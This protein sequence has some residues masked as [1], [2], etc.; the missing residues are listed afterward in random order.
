MFSFYIP[1][2]YIHGSSR[3][4]E[5]IEPFLPNYTME[6]Y[7]FYVSYNQTTHAFELLSFHIPTKTIEFIDDQFL[8]KNGENNYQLF[9]PYILNSKIYCGIII[10]N[11]LPNDFLVNDIPKKMISFDTKI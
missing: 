4:Y 7:I 6:N 1:L 2:T 9:S 5:S 10:K 3:L 11:Q 8:Y